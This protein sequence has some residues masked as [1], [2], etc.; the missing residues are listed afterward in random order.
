MKISVFGMGYVGSVTAACLAESGHEVWGVD[1]NLEKVDMIN[2]GTSP[3]VEERIAEMIAA[4]R[5]SGALCATAD[6]VEALAATELSLVCVGTPSNPNGSLDL[7]AVLAAS[8]E[9][10]AGLKT[11]DRHHTV[12]YR[13]TVLPGSVR[14][15]LI[16]ALE[17]TSGKQA[18]RDFD[19]CMHP[20]F[21]REGSSVKDFYHPPF[22]VI[23]AETTRG[24]DLVAAMYTGIDA[25]VER[26]SYEVAEMLKY[27]CNTFHALKV[28]Y[29]NEVGAL[30]RE[31][32]I[33]SHRVMELFALDRKLNIS[34]A[35]LRPGF[36]FGGPCLP[37]DLKALL[38]KAKEAD[39]HLPVLDSVLDSNRLHLER[40]VD[41][42]LATRERRVGVLGLS[43]KP[44]TD[45]LRDSPIVTLIE[46]LIGKG[47]QIQIHDP[48]VLLS[49]IFGANR[50]YIEKEIPHISAL[51][52]EDLDAL[53]RESAVI[54]V[55]KASPRFDAAL[56]P[57]LGRK[58]VFDLVRLPS[59]R[60]AGAEPRPGY[61]G[62]CW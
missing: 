60:G 32:G 1:V 7:S 54:V 15:V 57:Y 43:F 21:L 12:A 27:A 30:C 37:K 46:T 55:C 18:H 52:A 40:V 48:D 10:G 20:E 8:R 33:D 42:I 36:A 29:A 44:G 25:P 39:V 31:L 45:D 16:P 41:R 11:L 26:T 61:E 3:I 24:G 62:I 23:G 4:S 28:T 59:T 58:R 2:A 5:Q 22:I 51:M 35:Y 17:E 19:V 49:K 34:P 50:R 38:Y 6:P 47:C 9:I 14:G 56:A 53:L 13:S